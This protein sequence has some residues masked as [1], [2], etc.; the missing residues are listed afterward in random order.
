VQKAARLI[1][2]DYFNLIGKLDDGRCADFKNVCNLLAGVS[3]QMAF[4]ALS[5]SSWTNSKAPW[6][7][8]KK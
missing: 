3:G 2:E 1:I 8:A 5:P 6:T 7:R 4:P